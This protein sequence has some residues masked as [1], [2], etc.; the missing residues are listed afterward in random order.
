MDQGVPENRPIAGDCVKQE[1]K[2]PKGEY[3]REYEINLKFL[4]IGCVISVGCKSIPFTSVKEG[5]DALNA[6]VE[7]PEEESRKWRKL[8]ESQ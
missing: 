4:S 1:Y 8:F 7:N 2:R 3:L 5:M 6:Y